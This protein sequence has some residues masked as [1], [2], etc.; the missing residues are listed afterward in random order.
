[1]R[2]YTKRTF[3]IRSWSQLRTLPDLRQSGG[4][5][6]SLQGR[7]NS[8]WVWVRVKVRERRRGTKCTTSSTQR[9]L[10]IRLIRGMGRD[11]PE[12]T[13]MTGVLERHWP[14]DS[15]FRGRG[16][17]FLD[18]RAELINWMTLHL[19]LGKMQQL[20]AR[21]GR[22]ETTASSSRTAPSRQSRDAADILLCAL[23]TASC[24]E[25]MPTH[26]QIL[27]ILHGG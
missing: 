3:N 19:R 14:Q 25:A 2:T 7:Y 9:L 6:D 15:P 16:R 8:S 1:M 23:D 13:R 22:V 26:H 18:A 27:H 5:R 12:T 11:V 17:W 20:Q 21:R 10:Q 24:V 4:K